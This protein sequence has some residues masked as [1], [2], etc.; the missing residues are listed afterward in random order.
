M[1]KLWKLVGIY[2]SLLLVCCTSTLISPFYPEI[3]KKKGLSLWMIGAIF[4]LNPFFKLMASLFLGKY[5]MRIGRKFVLLSSLLLT[6]VS[7]IIL[8]PIE[9]VELTSLTI[10]SIFSKLLG[11]IGAG[12]VFTSI[13]TIFVSDYP[14]QIQIMIGRM[15]AAVGVGLIVGPLLGSA[16][17]LISLLAALLIVGGLIL[18]FSPF[19]W[20]MLGTFKDYEVHNVTIDRLKLFMKPVRY[21]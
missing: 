14:D 17:Y 21:I 2:L 11:G 6:S 12:C 4:S 5:M 7:M 15:E 9:E 1:G 3:A 18:A 10:L 8:S 19:A 13:T 20:K 16:L